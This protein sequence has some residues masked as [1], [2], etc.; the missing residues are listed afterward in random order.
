MCREGDPHARP[1]ETVPGVDPGPD[2]RAGIRR[3]AGHPIQSVGAGWPRLDRP[4]MS[5]PPVDGGADRGARSWRRARDPVHGVP[6][7]GV[8]AVRA[9]DIW[10]PPQRPAPVGPE[11]KDGDAVEVVDVSSAQADVVPADRGAAARRAGHARERIWPSVRVDEMNALERTSGCRSNAPRPMISRSRQLC[12]RCSTRT[13][14]RRA[15][16]RLQAEG[17][18]RSTRTSRPTAPQT[19]PSLSGRHT[20]SRR[21]R[22]LCLKRTTQPRAS[23]TSRPWWTSECARSTTSSRSNAPPT[24][25]GRS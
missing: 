19:D 3:C 24:G 7:G 18:A 8:A 22:T 16:P 13:T 12:N 17:S 15:L 14:R 1:V 21:R 6:P 2:R 5:F 25:L 4:A 10:M 23:P 9:H 20:T 11:S